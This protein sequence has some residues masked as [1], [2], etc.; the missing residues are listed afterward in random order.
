MFTGSGFPQRFADQDG[1]LIDVYQATTQLTDESEIDIPAHIKTLID[2]ATSALGYYGVFTANMH[3]DNDD[4]PGADAIIAEATSRGVPVI[5]AAQLL[6]W[7]DGRNDSSFGGLSFAGNQ[8]SFSVQPG[9]GATGLQAMV[10]TV[11][12][13]GAFTNLFRNGSAVATTLRTVKGVDYRVFDAAP[14]AYV[15]TYGSAPPVDTT[16][17]SATVTGSSAAFTFAANQLGATFECA[18]DADAFAPCSSPKSYSGLAAGS[19]TFRARAIVAG[20]SDPT[21]AEAAITVTPAGGVGTPAPPSSGSG[22]GSSTTNKG[23]ETG[24]SGVAHGVSDRTAPRITLSPRT[25][26]LSRNGTV[27][28]R[29]ACPRTE[30]RCHVQLRL[31]LR[32]RYVAS[33]TLTVMG[34]RTRVFALKLRAATRHELARRRALTVTAVAVASDLAGN[35]VRTTTAIRLLAPASR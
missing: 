3:T 4:N 8:L 25:L 19:H 31:R 7:L 1:S 10:P 5:S 32:G 24:A 14:G 2:N 12:P 29:V 20:V 18:L 16:I 30:Q 22:S 6:T 21:P 15:A 27:H 35:R 9:S 26:R 33:K 17:A 34:G 28:V 23:A 11:G 13:T